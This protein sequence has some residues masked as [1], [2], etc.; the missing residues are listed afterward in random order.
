MI[1]DYIK[2]QHTQIASGPNEFE[3]TE[4]WLLAE[5]NQH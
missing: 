3:M 2:Q 1:D 5:E 4:I